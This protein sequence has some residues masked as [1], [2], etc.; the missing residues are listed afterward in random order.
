[1]EIS[2]KKYNT[3]ED[4]L[5]ANSYI[6]KAEENE[7]TKRIFGII[8][9]VKQ[10]GHFNNEK[11]F[12]EVCKWKSPRRPDLYEGNEK[13]KINGIFRQIFNIGSDEDEGD[14]KKKIHLLA[15]EKGTKKLKGV[16][17]GVGSAILMF[18]NPEKYGVLDYHVWD[19]L[20][21][22]WEPLSIKNLPCDLTKTRKREKGVD[23]NGIGVYSYSVDDWWLYIKYL[24]K[25]AGQFDTTAR[26]IERCLFIYAK[27]KDILEEGLSFSPKSS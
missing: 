23:R 27:C 10:K 16:G 22:D 7:K 3:I 18:L 8:E 24:R 1:M 20:T 12:V 13:E 17:V 5:T 19:L 9:E 15:F 25:W 26:R 2:I 6:L 4:L 11:D 14:S 21:I